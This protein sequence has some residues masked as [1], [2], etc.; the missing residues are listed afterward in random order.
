MVDKK[1][2][3]HL[4]I[5]PSLF[6]SCLI[7]LP[8]S[9]FSNVESRAA[10]GTIFWMAY[11][12]VTRPVDYAIAAFLPMAINAILPMADMSKVLPNYWSETVLLLFAAS[13]ITVSW[14]E[15]GL[16]KR[17][18]ALFLRLIGNGVRNQLIFWFLLST[19]LSTILPN[20]VV[21]ATITPIAV[22]MLKY[23]GHNSIEDSKVGSLL[24]LTIAFAVGIG[25]LATPLG[26]AMNLVTVDYIQQITGEEY[27]YVDWVVRFLPIMIILIISNLLYL[28]IGTKKTDTLGGSKEYF[29]NEYKKMA[30]MSREEWISLSLFL[31]ATIL[32]FTRQTYKD[33]LPG[34]K[35]AYSF[36][37]CAMVGFLFQKHDGSKLM[38]WKSAQGKIIWE[39][40][41][42]FGGGMAAGTLI[43]GSG[44]ADSIGA[45]V[46]QMGLNG[47]LVAVGVFIAVPMILANVTS[48]TGT[49]AVVV[50]IVISI[51]N[52]IHQNP[53]P[54]IYV[55]TIGVNLAYMFPTSIRA[56]PVGYGLSPKY[57]LKEGWKISL[58]T[59]VLM[60]ISGWLLLTYWP[61]FSN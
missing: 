12:W 9:I 53:I 25:G 51:A 44:A 61:A 23:A 58:L 54:Y 2:L 45:A 47:G 41:F 60:T 10:V 15:T 17:I 35:P 49:A 59:W 36:L 42:I 20:S 3:I 4:I 46:S 29:E 34:L 31:I 26:G 38:T 40:L 28:L 48:N 37:I 43:T 50:P 7:I 19:A 21:C 56:V 5:G 14:E 32:A 16:D 13:I 55:A 33:L 22:A 6:L 8:S 1:R 24:L 27:M 52:G 39:L 30:K 57:M 11:W 18:A